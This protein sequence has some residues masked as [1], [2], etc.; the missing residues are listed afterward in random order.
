MIIKS[1]Q[2]II[3][4]VEELVKKFGAFENVVTEMNRV[5]AQQETDINIVKEILVEQ[6]VQIESFERKCNLTVTNI[7]DVDLSFNR[8]TVKDDE[9]KVKHLLNTILPQKQKISNRDI[10]NLKVSDLDGLAA[11]FA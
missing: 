7:P 9:T 4:H 1:E 8:E 10:F 11:T 2:R 5:Q 3:Q 6:Q